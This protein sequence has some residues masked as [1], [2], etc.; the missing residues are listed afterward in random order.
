VTSDPD[1]KVTSFL[2]SNIEKK[3]RVLKHTNRRLYLT[4]GMVLVP[5]SVAGPGLVSSLEAQ[6]AKW[7]HMAF[8]SKARH[9]AR[10]LKG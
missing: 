5:Q 7:V 1:F 3:W 4:Y 9:Y 2:K 6:A 8:P 10:T